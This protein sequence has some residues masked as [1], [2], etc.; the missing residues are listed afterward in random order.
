MHEPAD[1]PLD[2]LVTTNRMIN[3][4][5]FLV[6]TMLLMYSV[7]HCLYSVGNKIATKYYY[8]P[9]PVRYLYC[10][11]HPGLIMSSYILYGLTNSC[12]LHNPFLVLY[13]YGIFVVEVHFIHCFVRYMYV[14]YLSINVILVTHKPGGPPDMNHTGTEQA[15]DKFYTKQKGLGTDNKWTTT[16]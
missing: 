4:Y 13:S 12:P 3:V 10:T 15:A 6:V 8:P 7:L 11:Y 1:G 16:R 2:S 5:G 14:R 9:L